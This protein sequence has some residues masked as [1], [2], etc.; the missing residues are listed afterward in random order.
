MSP[1][2]LTLRLRELMPRDTVFTTDVGAIKSI[3]S[4]ACSPSTR[5]PSSSPTACRR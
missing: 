2:E 5:S 4:Q 1:Y 3:T